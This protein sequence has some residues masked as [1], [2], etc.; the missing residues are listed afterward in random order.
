MFRLENATSG[1]RKKKNPQLHNN[2]VKLHLLIF[3]ENNT[4]ALVILKRLKFP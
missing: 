4:E 3:W 1:E 2:Y